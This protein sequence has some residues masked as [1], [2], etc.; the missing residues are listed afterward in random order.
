MAEI[1]NKSFN[2][3]ERLLNIN[4]NRYKSSNDILCTILVRLIKKEKI[5]KRNV[6]SILFSSFV[7][8]TIVKN[9]INSISVINRLNM[10]V[11]NSNNFAGYIIA[12][13]ISGYILFY[14][15][16]TKETIKALVSH[17][18]NVKN[19]DGEN[20][21]LFESI[22]NYFVEI[23]VLIIVFLG[24]NFFI[25]IFVNLLDKFTLN[26]YHKIC[27]FII[28]DIYIFLT[29]NLLIEFLCFIYNLYS[30]TL[31]DSMMKVLNDD[32]NT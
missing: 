3:N 16:V 14:T 8:Y 18:D 31:S 2:I 30:L 10:V 12:G 11:D 21:T 19:K 26:S 32:S 24:I 7:A 6:F 9:S 25:K 5:N 29:I 27:F 22:N 4:K 17:D 1:N 13:I 20:K 23:L 15:I 28:Y